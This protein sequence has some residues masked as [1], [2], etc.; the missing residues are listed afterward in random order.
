MTRGSLRRSFIV[1]AAACAAALFS[2][3]LPDRAFAQGAFPNKPIHIIVGFAA[4]GG[5]DVIARIVAQK[6]TEHYGQPVL[7][8]NRTG[9]GGI[10]ATEYVQRAAA[11]GYTILTGPMGIM[12]VN[13][14]VY[15]KLAYDPLKD[16]VAVSEIASFPLIM[17]VNPGSNIHSIKELVEY[18]KAHPDKANYAAPA[19]TFQ[20]TM[21]LF[22]LKTGAPFEFIAYKGSNVSVTA[23]ISGEA[24]ASIIDSGP[25]APPLK[26]GQVR[27]LAITSAQRSPDFP[28]IPT[29]AEAGVPD[30]N[31]VSWSGFFVPAGTPKDVVKV[32]QDETIRIVKLPDVRERMHSLGLDPVGNTSEEFTKLIGADIAR[33]TAVAKA[34]N[35]HLD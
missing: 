29:M 6:M 32:L 31:V 17:L 20:L 21:E 19:T 26:N 1:T 4:G 9:A 16:F 3:A 25:A 22:K 8:E 30:M 5:N 34:A 28:D 7:V 10:I 35:I 18:A 15:S 14:A 11:D 23:V 2:Q 27:G 24:L 12:G 13:P 33:W